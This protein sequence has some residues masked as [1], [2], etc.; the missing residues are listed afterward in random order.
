MNDGAS[1]TMA[2][3]MSVAVGVSCPASGQRAGLAAARRCA[4]ERE[5]RGRIAGADTDRTGQVAQRAG[6]VLFRLEQ[7][8]HVE[9]CV[10]VERIASQFGFE[11]TPSLVRIARLQQCLS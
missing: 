5:T 8:A 7:E 6:V 10:E 4:G 9:I 11:L 1:L 3:S 2:S